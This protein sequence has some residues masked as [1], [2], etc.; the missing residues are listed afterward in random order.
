MRKVES[1]IGG[2]GLREWLIFTIYTLT[3]SLLKYKKKK[4]INLTVVHR[5]LGNNGGNRSSFQ[6]LSR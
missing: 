5:E 2:K 6:K 4:S 3:A 1:G